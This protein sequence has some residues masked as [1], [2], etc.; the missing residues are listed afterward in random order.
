M[1]LATGGTGRTGS[2]VVRAL[3]ERDARVRVLVRDPDKARTLFGDEVEIATGDFR[4][5]LDDVDAVF[6]SGPDDPR[7]VAWETAA[8]D[9]AGE[10]RVVRLSTIGAVPGAPVPFWDWHGQ[11][12]EHL[13][14]SQARWTILQSSFFLSNLPAMARDGVVYA[15]AGDALIAMID[16]ADVADVAAEVLVDGGHERETLV[17]TGPE[18]ITFAQA[19]GSLGLAF[20]D[21][22]LEAAPQQFRVLFEQLRAGAVCPC[23]PSSARRGPDGKTAGSS[24][25]PRSTT[26]A[27]S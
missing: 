6:L 24:T 21:V 17:L 22:P 10:R 12:D 13:R 25:S 5:A 15:P 1:V 7:R 9:A 20:V 19:A 2:K 3:L 14:V 27:R 8:I 26:T 16:P 4:D 18:A 11:V 23:S